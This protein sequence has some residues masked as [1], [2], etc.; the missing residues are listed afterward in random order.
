MTLVMLLARLWM[1]PEKL[2]KRHSLSAEKIQKALMVHR[3]LFVY[4][5]QIVSLILARAAKA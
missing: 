3:R 5:I 2:K 4:T 1:P